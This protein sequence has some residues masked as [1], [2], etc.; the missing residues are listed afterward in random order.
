MQVYHRSY[1]RVLSR[2]RLECYPR[3]TWLLDRQYQKIANL[4]KMQ[5]NTW[6]DPKSKY[7]NVEDNDPKD[8]YQYHRVENRDHLSG[9]KPLILTTSHHNLQSTIYIYLIYVCK[10][11]VLRMYVKLNMQQIV[12]TQQSVLKIFQHLV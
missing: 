4:Q 11:Y 6:P 10:T 12:L 1:Y 8:N 2:D 9:S 7:V 5:D 3:S